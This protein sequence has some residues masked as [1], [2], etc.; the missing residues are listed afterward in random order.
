MSAYK[1]SRP[2]NELI[3]DPDGQQAP[4]L[5]PDAVFEH[6]GQAIMKTADLCSHFKV[7]QLVYLLRRRI[8][9]CK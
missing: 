9:T 4:E 5:D 1:L 6:L 8:L 3:E 7:S 2:L